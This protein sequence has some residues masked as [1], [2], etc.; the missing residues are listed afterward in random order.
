MKIR[1]KWR[2]GNLRS[3]N[4]RSAENW[5]LGSWFKERERYCCAITT[6][7]VVSKTFM[8]P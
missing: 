2:S 1:E 7:Q 6:L 5:S 3:G 8:T 4:L